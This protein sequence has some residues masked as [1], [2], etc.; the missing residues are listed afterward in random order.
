MIILGVTALI[1]YLVLRNDQRKEV[2]EQFR[3]DLDRLL[4][5]GKEG[6][7]SPATAEQ[8]LANL[9]AEIDKKADG[10]ANQSKLLRAT[11]AERLAKRFGSSS[12]DF[13]KDD[14]VRLELIAFKRWQEY[15][16][17]LARDHKAN[18]LIIRAYSLALGN[19][20]KRDSGFVEKAILR[21]DD[22]IDSIR[23]K[24]DR[25]R[26]LLKNLFYGYRHH[27]GVLRETVQRTAT[28]ESKDGL[29]LS[30]CWCYS[31]TRNEKLTQSVFGYDS[32]IFSA[33]HKRCEREGFLSSAN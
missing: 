2:D 31:A 26:E 9:S 24:D 32:A 19:L 18:I 5:P 12:F 23:P 28:Q 6:T 22:G 27:Q 16:D 4:E 21:S 15:R 29:L 8:L 17:L 33:E 13:N 30:F 10:D 11:V 7:I 1:T 14:N 3:V 25:D 20:H